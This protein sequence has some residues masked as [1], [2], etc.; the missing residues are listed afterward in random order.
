MD[1]ANGAEQKKQVRS[2]SQR[3]VKLKRGCVIFLVATSKRLFKAL[4]FDSLSIP[5]ATGIG[6]KSTRRVA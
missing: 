5:I 4:T 6:R 3:T 2:L 1:A